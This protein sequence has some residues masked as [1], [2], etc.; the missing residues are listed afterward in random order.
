MGSYDLQDLLIKIY[1]IIII[2]MF[3]VK[4]HR[5]KINFIID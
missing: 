5:L 4:S 1:F 3:G 2:I